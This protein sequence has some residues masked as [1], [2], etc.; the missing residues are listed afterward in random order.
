MALVPV[1]VAGSTSIKWP[2]LSSNSTSYPVA[3]DTE[4]DVGQRGDPAEALRPRLAVEGGG[5][6]T[7][8]QARLAGR[9]SWRFRVESE[10]PLPGPG[11]QPVATVHLLHAPQDAQDVRVELWLGRTLD[12]LPVRMRVTEADGD[13]VESNLASAYAQPT[14]RAP[15]RATTP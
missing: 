10:E 7:D 14:P 8:V 4:L 15:A 11:G 5:R 2:S 9:G 13:V 3:P 12:Y 1:T 6:E